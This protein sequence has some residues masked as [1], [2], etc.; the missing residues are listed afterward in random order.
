MAL[1]N[2][3]ADWKKGFHFRV[4]VIDTWASKQDGKYIYANPNDAAWIFVCQLKRRTFRLG[5]LGAP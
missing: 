1:I 4:I 3:K 2:E 5:R